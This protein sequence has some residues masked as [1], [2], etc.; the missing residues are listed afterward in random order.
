MF[1][2]TKGMARDLYDMMFESGWYSLEKAD[3]NKIN[4]VLGE[5]ETNLNQLIISRIK[6][7]KSHGMKIQNITEHF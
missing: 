1:T 3:K 5:M 7:S 2:E 4:E 6:I